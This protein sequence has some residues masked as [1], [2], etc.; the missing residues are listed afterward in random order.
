VCEDKVKN[1]A[2]LTSA[3]RTNL[4]VFFFGLKQG[5]GST[6]CLFWVREQIKKSREKKKGQWGGGGLIPGQLA[7]LGK[8]PKRPEKP[9]DH[10]RVDPPPKP[11]LARKRQKTKNP[12]KKISGGV[13]R[14]PSN[15]STGGVVGGFFF[16]SVGGEILVVLEKGGPVTW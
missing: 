1:T 10:Q 2:S 16:F 5:V 7:S 4:V 9:L 3:P 12:Y 14:E 11:T 8:S 6:P 13:R 15:R